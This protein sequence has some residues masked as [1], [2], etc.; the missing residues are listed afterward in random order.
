MLKTS[1]EQETNIP[2]EI[3]RREKQNSLSCSYS[4]GLFVKS[5]RPKPNEITFNTKCSQ[6]CVLLGENSTFRTRLY[7]LEEPVGLFMYKQNEFQF[8]SS[9]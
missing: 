4:W 7:A 8:I 3:N 6:K 5:N 9:I 2:H 1:I